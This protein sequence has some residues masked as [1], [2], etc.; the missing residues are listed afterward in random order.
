VVLPQQVVAAV[1][2]A[3]LLKQVKIAVLLRVAMAV[4][5]MT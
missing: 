4:Q 5:A 2:A 3:V 1:A